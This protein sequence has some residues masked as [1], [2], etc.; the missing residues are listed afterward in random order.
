MLDVSGCIRN[1][2][3]WGYLKM[4]GSAAKTFSIKSRLLFITVAALVGM[5]LIA[6]FALQ[7]ERATLLEDRKVKTRN[8]VESAHRMLV[9]FSGLQQKGVLS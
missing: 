7:S 1:A 5:I 9:H 2:I 3:L 8:L 6:V 4:N